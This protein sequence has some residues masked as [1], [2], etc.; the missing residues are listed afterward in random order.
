M[1]FETAFFLFEESH[2]PENLYRIR[3][4]SGDRN[5]QS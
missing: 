4:T 3:Q 5:Y 1:L 2:I